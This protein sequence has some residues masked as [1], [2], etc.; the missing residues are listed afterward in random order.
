[1]NIPQKYLV[2]MGDVEPTSMPRPDSAS[3]YWRPESCVGQLRLPGCQVSLGI[4]DMTPAQAVAAGARTL[5]IGVAPSAAAF[6]P[7]GSGR[8]LRRSRPDSTWRAAC[9]R[10]WAACLR[11]RTRR[12]GPAVRCSTCVMQTAIFRSARA[13]S[14]PASGCSPWHRLCRRQEIHRASDRTRSAGA[15]HQGHLPGDGPDRHSDLRRGR[16]DR[17]GGRGLHRRSRRV[18]LAGQRRRPLGRHRGPGLAVPSRL[19]RR[20]H[21]TAARLAA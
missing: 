15:R 5:V 19:R 13:G 10:A 9:T 2:F 4:P 17:C 1:M 7:A 12:A 8:S 21:G 6:S 16:R 20:E 3:S 11:L 14:A 18:A